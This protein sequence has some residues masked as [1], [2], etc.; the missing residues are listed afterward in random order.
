[1]GF[2]RYSSR[3]SDRQRNMVDLTGKRLGQYQIVILLGRG[4]MAT[5]Y[6]AYQP[7]MKRHVALKVIWPQANELD[8]FA[9]RFEREAQLVASL[10]H[11]HILKVFDYGQE[12]TMVYLAME[13]VSGNLAALIEKGPIAPPRANRIFSEVASA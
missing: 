12:D 3:S 9:V 11:P 13:L 7:S 2:D 1:I 4:G 5:V 8:N 10:S 6:R